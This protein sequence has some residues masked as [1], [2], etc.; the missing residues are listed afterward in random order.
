MNTVIILEENT[1]CPAM[2]NCRELIDG[3]LDDWDCYFEEMQY[4][5]AVVLA[6]QPDLLVIDGMQAAAN[7][8]ERYLTLVQ[9][10]RTLC[11]HVPILF[12]CQST[13]L[14]PL[15]ERERFVVI[16]KDDVPYPQRLIEHI[17]AARSAVLQPGIR[18]S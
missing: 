5:A 17:A 15:A 18:S 3:I 6:Y 13:A 7:N 4:T 11:R 12:V 16:H 1:V 2:E 14:L 9:S 8:C 10:I